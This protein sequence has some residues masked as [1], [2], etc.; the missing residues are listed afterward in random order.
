MQNQES[1]AKQTLNIPSAQS[2]RDVI[3]YLRYSILS[4]LKLVSVSSPNREVLCVS[5]PHKCSFDIVKSPLRSQFTL[6]ILVRDAYARY[7]INSASSKLLHGMV[8]LLAF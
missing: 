2:G 5:S 6:E 7:R 1:R 8:V 4:E 3:E